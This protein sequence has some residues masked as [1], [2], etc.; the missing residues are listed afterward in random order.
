MTLPEPKTIWQHWNGI[1]YEVLM[2]ANVTS[3]QQD[4]YPTT[5]VYQNVINKNV[6]TRRADDWH[7]SFTPIKDVN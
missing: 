3:K 4:K 5:V 1:N 6:F 7:R 2:I